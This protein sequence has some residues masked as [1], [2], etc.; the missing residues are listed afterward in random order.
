M[1]ELRERREEARKLEQ[2]QRWREALAAYED[3]LEA[4]DGEETDPA[5]LNRVGD[6]R[7]RIGETD[8]AIEAYERAV[9]AYGDAGLQNNAIALCK[10]ILRLAPGRIP[11]HLTLGRLNAANGFLADAR[12]SFL[13]YTARAGRVGQI[14]EA[15]DALRE[16]AD[17]SPDDADARRLLAEQLHTHD[18][19]AEALE[20]LRLLIGALESRGALDQI[21]AVR[22]RIREIDPAAEVS[23]LEPRRSKAGDAVYVDLS[24]GTD[25][26]PPASGGKVPEK[27]SG[28]GPVE[29]EQTYTSPLL[30]E[31][32]G[33][34]ETAISDLES[35][36]AGEGFPAVEGLEWSNAFED[37]EDLEGF[38]SEEIG[39]FDPETGTSDPTPHHTTDPGDEEVVPSPPSTG[40][41][42]GDYVDLEALLLNDE[43]PRETTRFVIP[44][45]PS[46]DEHQDLVKILALFRKRVSSDLRPDDHAS[47][48]DLGLAFRSMGLLDEAIARFQIALQVGAD[49]LP[50]LEMLGLCFMERGLPAVATRVFIRALHTAGAEEA[51]LVGVLYHL[52][53]CEE[54]AGRFDRAVEL[55]QRVL[56][57]DIFFRDTAARLE[58]LPEDWRESAAGF[59]SSAA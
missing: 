50:T 23:A 39:I 10:K 55:Y 36:G 46:G 8:L 31:G 27:E 44:G 29:E 33:Y 59:D 57:I 40:L 5:L 56:A 14:E 43:P 58:T 30:R 15:L 41:E 47:H 53:R 49:P 32:S 4:I 35:Y 22:D 13:E 16:L 20:Q 42:D 25:P 37:E 48:Y 38:G 12:G 51:D 19:R 6:L 21:D 9:E 18:Q 3:V 28:P 54:A 52:G 34:G 45:S 11:V 24:R 7:V 17:L 26:S 2:A 1:P